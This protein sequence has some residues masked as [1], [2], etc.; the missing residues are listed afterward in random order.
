MS[1]INQKRQIGKRYLQL[2]VAE[3][4]R[5]FSSLR[6]KGLKLNGQT[7]RDYE[8]AIHIGR[9]GW[10]TGLR[11][12]ALAPPCQDPEE[13]SYPQV[14]QVTSGSLSVGNE[15]HRRGQGAV[16]SVDYIQSHH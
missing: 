4:R 8:E 10:P 6:R 15:H 1:V 14:H 12:C 5:N 16:R 7:F 9:N 13:F 2:L 3:H 11:S